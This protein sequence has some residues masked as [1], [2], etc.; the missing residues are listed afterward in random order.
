MSKIRSFTDLVAWQKGHDL[1]I[2]IYIITKGFPSE[3]KFGLSDQMRRCAISI[4]SNIAEGFSRKSK[5][6]KSQF[7]YISLGS[8]TELQN[9]LFIAKDLKYLS[10]NK[11]NQLMENTITISKL[12]N[13]LIKSL[14]NNS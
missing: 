1:V 5:K 3:E 11:F 4:T 2:E 9:H 8:I 13:G 14:N 12:I 10:E 7:L 6:E